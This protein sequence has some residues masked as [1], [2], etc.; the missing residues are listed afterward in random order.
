[1]HH[2]PGLQKLP[3]NGL[4]DTAAAAGDEHYFVFEKIGLEHV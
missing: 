2:C 3:G 1:V 4:S